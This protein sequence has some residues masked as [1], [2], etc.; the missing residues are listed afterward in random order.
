MVSVVYD[1]IVPAT[2]AGV[3]RRATASTTE[4]RT[5][6]ARPFPLRA[7][8][9]SSS[10]CCVIAA[11][12]EAPRTGRPRESVSLL[13][14]RLRVSLREAFRRFGSPAAQV[15]GGVRRSKL[16]LLPAFG[17]SLS[18]RKAL[19]CGATRSNTNPDAR[20]SAAR[21]A[22]TDLAQP[23]LHPSPRGSRRART[24]SFA[25][26]EKLPEAG[27][28]AKARSK[29]KSMVRSRTTDSHLV[30]CAIRT[31]RMWSGRR[32]TVGS[33]LER[34]LSL[35]RMASKTAG[36]VAPAPSS[37]HAHAGEP[38]RLGGRGWSCFRR[39]R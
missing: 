11:P 35:G 34:V 7:S 6:A 14:L 27:T 25:S 29:F 13:L 22:L 26:R 16:R 5:A 1:T 24:P 38:G 10:A 39:F 15:R 28:A 3:E 2:A 17:R 9:T 21:G 30:D 4:P 33:I 19:S 23:P 32:E 12:V 37:H 20:S 18:G 31:N 36:R 8:R